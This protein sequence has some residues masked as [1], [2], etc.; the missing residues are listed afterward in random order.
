[1]SGGVLLVL[2]VNDSHVLD[3]F[4]KYTDSDP[5]MLRT[6]ILDVVQEEYDFCDKIGWVV[7]ALKETMLSSWIKY[8]CLP[9]ACCD[10]FMLYLL[11]RI[12][13]RH[14]IMY[15]LK[16][17]WTTVHC[18]TGFSFATLPDLCHIHL[19]YLGEHL[20]GELY[21][22][23][24]SSAPTVTPYALQIPTKKIKKG[25]QKVLDLSCREQTI[26]CDEGDVVSTEDSVYP[27]SLNQSGLPGSSSSSDLLCADGPM[28]SSERSV[29]FD[30]LNQSGSMELPSSSCTSDMLFAD[31]LS[32]SS[33]TLE[34]PK[35]SNGLNQSG[36]IEPLSSSGIS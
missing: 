19:V 17:P 10:K 15:T 11:C 3:L 14:A 32:V 30:G 28:V 13:Y 25:Q 23:P 16:Q 9:Y 22:L 12:H 36:M 5:F 35:N 2:C 8:M 18:N 7:L 6:K 21:P 4:C 34:A 27:D 33:E 31:G 20:Y 1:M 29:N 24:M 26:N